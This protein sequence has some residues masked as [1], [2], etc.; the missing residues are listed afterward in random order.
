MSFLSKETGPVLV[1]APHPDDEVLGVGGTMRK[2]AD[3]GREVHVCV[4]TRGRLPLFTEEMVATVRAEAKMAH[5]H[6]GVSRTHWLDQP[7]AELSSQPHRE[8][9]ASIGQLVKDV[10]PE[11][12]FIPHVGDLHMDHQLVFLSSLVASRPHQE[13]FP[14]TILAYETLSETN[15]NAPYVSPPFLPNVYVDIA[16]TVDRKL[17]AFA[18]FASQARPAPHERSVESLRALATLRGA[19]VHHMAA[20]AFVLVR[21]VSPPA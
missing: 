15:W 14:S 8:L 9:N 2:L 21:H 20:E 3:A 7:A 6:L 10:D 13:K 18:M 4:V 11:T 1:I 19:T 17:E 12:I 5:A 16:D